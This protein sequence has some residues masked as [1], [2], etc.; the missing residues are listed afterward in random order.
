MK[1]QKP[2]YNQ[3][4]LLGYRDLFY[5]VITRVVYQH[6]STRGYSYYEGYIAGRENKELNN[7][8]DIDNNKDIRLVARG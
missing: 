7:T 1:E 4:D 2:K 8:K 5:Y 3:G 6:N